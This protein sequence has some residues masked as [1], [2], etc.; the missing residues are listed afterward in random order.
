MPSG[1][2]TDSDASQ[3]QPGSDR[4]TRN[5][6]LVIVSERGRHS[7]ASRRIVR[8]QAARA[9]AAQSRETRARNREDR[10]QRDTPADGASRS[11]PSLNPDALSAN[12]R[13]QYQQDQRQRS[14]SSYLPYAQPPPQPLTSD[15]S[16]ETALTPLVNW[17]TNVLQLSAASLAAAGAALAS[18]AM[19][20]LESA[21]DAIA[22]AGNALTGNEDTKPRSERSGGLFIGNKL[23]AALPKGFAALERRVRLSDTFLQQLQRTAC[24]DFGS[25]GVDHRLNQLLFDIVMTEAASYLPNATSPPAHPIQGHL[26]IAC[27]CLTIVQGQQTEGSKFAED[28]KYAWG[29][30]AAWLE[31]TTLDQNALREPKSPEAALWAIFIISV[32]CGSTVHFFGQVIM[33]L[34]EEMQLRRWEEVRSLLINFIYPGSYLEAPCKQFYEQLQQGNIVH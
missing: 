4:P 21:G 28:E 18:A 22:Q 16:E 26:R 32:T 19:P 8:A 17:I 34:L 25:P 3:N 11:T 27:A 23:P 6:P 13:Q 2:E 33:G 1:Q 24:F 20:S 9:S 14:Q 15:R 12:P 29:L 30:Q 5:P 31:V 7:E 10:F